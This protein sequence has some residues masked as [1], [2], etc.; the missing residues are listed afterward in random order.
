LGSGVVFGIEAKSPEK[1]TVPEPPVGRLNGV[2]P[3]L[4]WAGSKR[5]IVEKLATYWR[6]DHKRYIEPFAG[7]AVLFF[8]LLPP[9][10]VL[11]DKNE[12]LIRTL[13]AV[14]DRPEDVYAELARLRPIKHIYYS[15]RARNP[16]TMNLVSRAARFLFLNRYCFNGL[17]RTNER[18]EFNVPFAGTTKVGRFPPFADFIRSAEAL[19]AA[20]IRAC[21]FGTTLKSV[22]KGDFVYLDPPFAVESRRVFREY[23]AR[24]FANQD[25]TRLE[26]HLETIHAKG[27]T[28]LLSYADCP[29]A[30]Q[31]FSNWKMERL[32]V[33][34]HVAG[35]SGAR[36]NAFELLFSNHG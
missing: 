6:T 22:R 30:R 32:R 3:F 35:F 17:Y 8:R 27:A 26:R 9:T 7:S 19:Q 13:T 36:R 20:T 21:D 25:L 5:Q 23:G 29:E 2:R 14:R 4:R 15:V 1:F 12:E 31:H 16:A 11:S 24:L 33:R 10:A 28:F 18:G 34:R